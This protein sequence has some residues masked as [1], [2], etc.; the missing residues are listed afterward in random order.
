MGSQNLLGADVSA[1]ALWGLEGLRPV[2]VTRL[3]GRTAIEV[4]YFCCRVAQEQGAP[5]A[6]CRV[7]DRRKGSRPCPDAPHRGPVAL[8]LVPV[9]LRKEGCTAIPA[10]PPAISRRFGLTVSAAEWV[11]VESMAAPFAEVARKAGCD[12]GK[13]G[14]VFAAIRP[15]LAAWRPASLPACIGID[16]VHTHDGTYTVIADLTAHQHGRGRVLELLATHAPVKVKDQL[17]AWPDRDRVKVV[18]LDP[19]STLR[20]VVRAV[21]PNATI[22]VDKRH[23]QRRALKC[24]H[25]VR[26]RHAG[27]VDA[28]RSRKADEAPA[29]KSLARALDKRQA[30][31]T[32]EDRG[33]VERAGPLV[34]AAYAA[35]EAFYAIYDQCQSPSAATAAVE[36][37][38]AGVPVELLDDFRPLH[39]LV[40]ATWA[41]EFLAYFRVSPRVTT[42]FVESVNRTL[43]GFEADARGNAGH[44]RLRGQLLYRFHSL[45]ADQLK[46]W[47]AAV[48]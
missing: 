17:M 22:V 28:Q 30:K 42:A 39:T 3:N 34:A 19:S 25:A 24:A 38:W 33:L 6:G 31:Q 5:C 37:W 29:K 16:G 20:A 13:V 44:A 15:A 35:K 4:E 32:A 12:D 46:A 47:L 9:R 14:A 7:H 26:K 23:V 18:V 10:L 40:T 27:S 41:D 45:S 2:A 21:F 36:A 43:R 8:T 11:L 1:S 48:L